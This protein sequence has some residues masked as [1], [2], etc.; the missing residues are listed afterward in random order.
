[1]DA[2]THAQWRGIP[3]YAPTAAT[4]CTLINNIVAPYVM[5]KPINDLCTSAATSR[6]AY[7]ASTNA[8]AVPLSILSGHQPFADAIAAIANTQFSLLKTVRAA[9]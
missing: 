7:V 3:E 1:M 9:T 8:V 6:D 2:A 5:L 4:P